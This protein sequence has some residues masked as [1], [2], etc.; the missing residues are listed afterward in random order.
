M[1]VN[2]YLSII[3]KNPQFP[4][5]NLASSLCDNIEDFYEE[6]KKAYSGGVIVDRESVLIFKIEQ[7]TSSL[8]EIYKFSNPTYQIP[9]I[10]ATYS[11]ADEFLK[12]TYAAALSGIL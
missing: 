2:F 3:I 1:K 4:K 5:V 12:D 11:D 7:D 6:V 8:K 10:K 9:K